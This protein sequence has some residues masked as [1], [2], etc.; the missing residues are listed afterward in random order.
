MRRTLSAALLLGLL[1]GLSQPSA[2]HDGADPSAASAA[3]VSVAQAGDFG[4]F[5]AGPSTAGALSRVRTKG[6]DD[7]PPEVARRRVVTADPIYLASRL[8]PEIAAPSLVDGAKRVAT[9]ADAVRLNLFAEIVV[10]AVLERFQ[11]TQSGDLIWQGALADGGKGSVHLVIAKGRITGAV[12][13]GGVSYSIFPDKD[14]NT[15]IDQID[16]SGFPKVG[17]HPIPERPNPDKRGDAPIWAPAPDGPS[18]AGDPNSMT[19]VTLLAAYTEAAGQQSADIVSEINLAVAMANTAY[20]N[21][22]ANVTLQLVGTIAATYTETGRSASTVLGTA[23]TGMASGTGE[24]SELYAARR[25]YGADLVALIV[26]SYSAFGACGI[27]Y[28]PINPVASD[29]AYGISASARGSCLSNHTLAHEVGHNMGLAHDRYAVR[30]YNESP[31]N[32]TLPQDFD[33]F[34]YSDTVAR[35]LTV[36]SYY[37][38]CNDSGVSC[39]RATRFSNPSAAFSNGAP[40]GIALGQTN[41]ANNARVLNVNKDVVATWRPADAGSIV[42]TVLRS[43]TGSGTVTSSPS[44]ISCGSTCS[45]TFSQNQSVTLTAAA[46]SGSTFAGWSS[47]CSGSAATATV[48]MSASASCG[49]TFTSSTSVTR[50]A[51][52]ALSAAVIMSGT[53]GAASGSNV[54]ATKETGEGNH[55]GNAGGKSVWWSWTPTGGGSATITTLGSTFDTLLAVY[56][57]SSVSA[58]TTIV[59]NDDAVGTTSSVTF[60]ATA[61]QSYFIA[62]D[63]Y[64][65]ASGSIALTWSQTISSAGPANNAFSSAIALTGASGTTSGTN[66]LASKETGEPRHAGNAGGASVWWKITPTAASTISV[67]TA[68]SSF[69]TTLGIYTG[70]AVS[71][72]TTVTSNDDSGGTLQSAVSFSASAGT[73]YYIA[74][75]GYD[76]A[77]GS[78]VLAFSGGSTASFTVQNGW[79]WAPSAPG[80]GL[81]IEQSGSNFFVGGYLYDTDGSAVWYVSSPT[82]T[83]MTVTGDIIEYA[84]GQT[85][86]GSYVAP[87]QRRVPGIWSIVFDSAT[88]GTLTWPAG[89]LAIQR[90]DIV[91]GGVAAGSVTGDPVKGWWYSASEGGSG[92]FIETQGADRTL[93]MAAYMYDT[94]GSAVWYVAG[95]ALQSGAFGAGL[96]FTGTL[97][98]YRDGLSLEGTW[99]MPSV[100][101]TRGSVSIQFVG[102]QQ[103]TLTL[104]GGR[105]VSLTRYPF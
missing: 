66:R 51:N 26:S 70:S 27:G 75:D 17:P 54:N 16:P 45:A 78:I 86:S 11:H 3:P 55:A 95:G 83:G 93:Y 72:L 61:G 87:V 71:G 100:A 18:I 39:T 56:T 62:V 4:L 84:N 67:N 1:L 23:R 8:S 81:G 74:V 37:D 5:R 63:G 35:E 79:W 77:T 19:I 15:V 102:T 9:S 28:M 104:P 43:G 69:D 98:E 99:R 38:A 50:P 13:A 36:M 96:T 85:L 7:L 25:L 32:G 29:A 59:S 24:L 21:S 60:T 42:L 30:K 91:S 65:G 44:G 46:A 97:T 48:V 14:G 10:E 101:A 53:S 57:G 105:Q 34:G 20:A 76:G 40:S 49:A 68:G 90:Y 22:G 64:A 47:S 82:L 88:T 31:W 73:T 89:T 94:D 33:Y 41:P 2:A 58:L 52:D 103:A 80:V 12:T 92:Y 6:I